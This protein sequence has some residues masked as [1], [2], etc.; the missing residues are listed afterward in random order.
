MQYVF[1]YSTTELHNQL[2]NYKEEIVLVTKLNISVQTLN[3]MLLILFLHFLHF[4]FLSNHSGFSFF[5]LT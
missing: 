1:K 3:A 2:C 5:C 4:P